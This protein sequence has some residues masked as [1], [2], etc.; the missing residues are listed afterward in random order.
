[1]NNKEQ[2]QQIIQ[3]WIVRISANQKSL[4]N[5]S[6]CPYAKSAKKIIVEPTEKIQSAN[7]FP[8][9][10]DIKI[11]VMNQDLSSR[12]LNDICQNLNRQYIDIICLPDHKNANTYINDIPTGN[13]KLNLI[14]CQSRTKLRS[15]RVRLANTTYY[16]YWPAEYLREI[17]EFGNDN[18]D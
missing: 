14:L 3:D 7:I 5:H 8:V 10:Y 18:L 9:D 4:D 17:L 15:A 13:G 16:H 6:V 1:M 11:F 2:Y 12:E